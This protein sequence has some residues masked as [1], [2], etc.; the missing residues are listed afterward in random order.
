MGPTAGA[1]ITEPNSYPSFSVKTQSMFIKVV[2]ELDVCA[3][4]GIE[5]LQG[6]EERV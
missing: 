2:E 1:K 3:W 4:D 6:R 5:G